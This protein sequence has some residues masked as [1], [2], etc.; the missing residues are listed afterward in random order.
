MHTPYAVTNIATTAA[1]IVHVASQPSILRRR[2]T[3]NDPMTTGSSAISIITIMI[4]TAITPL[5]TAL[6]NNALIG[7]I[8]VKSSATPATVASA[9]IA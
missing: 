5:M 2:V 6:Q 9:M 1:A 3:T 4:G 8:G 7:S